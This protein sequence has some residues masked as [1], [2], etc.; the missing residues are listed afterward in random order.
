MVSPFYFFSIIGNIIYFNYDILKHKVPQLY[1]QGFSLL[2]TPQFIISSQ[3]QSV[4]FRQRH[5]P[6][7]CSGKGK[8]CP[9]LP[10]RKIS[11]LVDLLY[12][13]FRLRV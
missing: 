9:T 12:T 3:Y 7:F 8:T 4:S 6:A 11:Q 2:W 10:S 5:L 1:G 13:A